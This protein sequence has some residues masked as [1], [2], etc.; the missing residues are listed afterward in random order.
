M[1]TL[2]S[3]ATGNSLAQYSIDNGTL[4]PFR[5]AGQ[6]STA[7]IYNLVSFQTGDLSCGSHRLFVQY[8]TDNPNNSAPLRLDY[9]IIHNRTIPTFIP[10]ATATSATSTNATPTSTPS[11]TTYARVSGKLS[12]GAVSGIVI[13]S[14]VGAAL[15]IFG[16]IW[17]IR[18][19]KRKS[20]ADESLWQQPASYEGYTNG[21]DT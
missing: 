9:F 7:Q 5:V 19:I 21:Q 4:F 1:T 11:H 15:I 2:T 13:G 14:L 3:E 8:G 6:T 16:L 18:F 20:V 12:S 10:N 17:V